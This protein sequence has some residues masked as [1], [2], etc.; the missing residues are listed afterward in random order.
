V[1]LIATGFANVS[2]RADHFQLHG[3]DFSVA[4]EAEYENLAVAFCNAAL[5][6]S[7]LQCVRKGN[8]DTIYYDTATDFFAVVRSDGVIKTFYKPEQRW[9]GFSSNLRYFQVECAK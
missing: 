5:K 8:G 6:P 7:R 9:H 4:T 3:Q 1:S 2:K